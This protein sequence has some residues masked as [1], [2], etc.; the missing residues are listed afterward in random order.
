MKL[1]A[2][3]MS[4][5]VCLSSPRWTASSG[6]WNRRYSQLVD[7][8]EA[9][10]SARSA[11]FRYG[12]ASRSRAG[13]TTEAEMSSS[14]WIL[15]AAAKSWRTLNVRQALLGHQ[16]DAQVGA[17]ELAVAVLQ[18]VAG[19]AVDHVHAE[20]AA[21]VVAPLRLVEPLDDEDDRVDVVGD[22][23]QPGVVLVGVVRRR[24]QQLDD[25]AQRAL[26]AR[27]SAGSARLA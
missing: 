17:D 24:R 15:A 8:L 20:V 18:L 3:A 14:V 25:A 12:A 9:G 21:P 11:V 19:E 23:R 2:R 7:E 4:A 27:G 10:A 5:S 22:R 1:S 13:T 26:V 6:R 16:A